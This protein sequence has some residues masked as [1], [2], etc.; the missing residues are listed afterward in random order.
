MRFQRTWAVLFFPLAALAADKPKLIIENISFT[1][2]WI[3]QNTGEAHKKVTKVPDQTFD[4]LS[5]N[6]WE[7]DNSDLQI[8]VDRQSDALVDDLEHISLN[9]PMEVSYVAEAIKKGE[10]FDIRIS[11]SCVGF[12]MCT[13]PS[14]VWVK[15]AKDSPSRR[16]SDVVSEA[17]RQGKIKSVKDLP[18]SVVKAQA[19]YFDEATNHKLIIVTKDGPVKAETD[20]FQQARSLKKALE[21]KDTFEVLFASAVYINSAKYI[22]IRN[23]V[24]GE[25][26][27]LED[28]AS[29]SCF[30]VSVWRDAHVDSQSLSR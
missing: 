3:D 10:I 17:A 21:D 6:H 15:T 20:S 13:S 23:K 7:Y 1:N 28:F 25:L 19:T 8:R 30:F 24:T 18:L 27:T 4:I 11:Y 26:S 29:L 9:S 16:L 22:F 2:E 12:F 5:M 14:N